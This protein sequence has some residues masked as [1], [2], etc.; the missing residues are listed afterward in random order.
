MTT[1]FQIASLVRSRFGNHA[2]T[3][4]A[5][6]AVA[7]AAHLSV[8]LYGQSAWGVNPT[9][10]PSGTNVG[11]GIANPSDRL[12]I[13][14]GRL[15]LSTDT[16]GGSLIMSQYAGLTR[17]T[18]AT[19]GSGGTVAIGREPV[20]V[21]G[22]AAGTY[23]VELWSG[24]NGSTPTLVANSGNVGIGTLYPAFELDVLGT[25]NVDGI[26][27]NSPNATS[28]IMNTNRGDGL[29]YAFGLNQAAAGDWGLYQGPS[30]GASAFGSRRIYITSNGNVFLQPNGGANVGI[31]TT[32]PQ[33]LLAVNGTIT[34]KE[35]VVT[36][37]GWPDYV[38]QPGYHLRPLTEVASF[39]KEHYHLPE[40]PSEAEVKE[41]G[42]SVGDMQAKLLAKI[43]ELTLHMIQAD[44][45]ST[46]L[47]MRNRELQDRIT[48][49][50]ARG[51][52]PDR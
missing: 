31:G 18:S 14:N 26:R 23:T 45:R 39:I 3:I 25:Q 43:E 52:Q 7:S 28:F 24:S 21:H 44:E 50:E 2:R 30:P 36:N 47:E 34:T 22:Q 48:R 40:I 5:V 32:T 20:L 13:Y 37:A 33:S 6:L 35:V 38:L 12:Q 1:M 19:S 51:V 42:V 10:V 9:W 29:N 8:P 15:Q 17:I 27:I 11:I 46:R 49:L 41:K 4:A 16:N